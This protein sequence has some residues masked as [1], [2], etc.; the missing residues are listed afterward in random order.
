MSSGMTIFSVKPNIPKELSSLKDIS[1]NLWWCWNPEGVELFKRIDRKLWDKVDH[2]PVSLLSKVSQERLEELKNSES[3]IGHLNM[4]EKKLKS[5]MLSDAWY[6]NNIVKGDRKKVKYAYFSAEFGI[7]ESLPVYSGGL[8]ILAGDHLKSASDLGLPLAAVGLLYSGGYFNQKLN[9]E[10][11]QVEEYPQNDFNNMGISPATNDKGEEVEI[12][13]D[14]KGTE[15]FAKVWETKVGR[16][17]LYLLDTNIAKNPIEYRDIT[18]QLYG[19]GIVMRIKQEILLG[20]GGVRALKALGIESDVYHMNEGHSAFL[21]VENIRDYMAQNKISFYDAKEAVIAESVF[22]THTPVPA[23]N[24]RFEVEMIKE[25]FTDYIKDLG[26][27]MDDFLALGRENVNDEKETFCMTVLALKL[28]GGAN[29]VSK[30]H[31][32][33]SRGM[34]TGV[35]KGVPEKEIPIGHIT[36]GIHVPSWV[37]DDMTILFDRYLGRRWREEAY[38]QELW[39]RVDNIPNTEL[40]RTHERLRARLVSFIRERQVVQLQRNNASDQAIE[41]AKGVFSSDV[42][43]IGFARR[44]ATYKRG[45]LLFKDMERLKKIIHNSDR[46]VQFVFAGKAHPADNGGKALIKAVVEASRDPE[47]KNHIIFLEDYR[48]DVARYLVQGVDI[49]LNNPIRPLEASGTSGMKVVSNGGLN[50]SIKDGWW[51]EGTNGQN[52]FDIG[53]SELYNDEETRDHLE[54]QAIYETLENTIIPAF[55]DR[56]EDQMPMKWLK[57]M[58]NSMKTLTGVYHTNRQVKDYTEMYYVVAEKN[59][60]SVKKDSF[61]Q[62]LELN[63]KKYV[64]YRDWDNISFGEVSIERGESFVG[65]SLKITVPVTLGGEISSDLIFVQAYY[66]VIDNYDSMEDP[67]IS[68]LKF[69]KDENGVSI[70]EGKIPLSTSGRY[71]LKIRIVPSEKNLIEKFA[72][73]LIAWN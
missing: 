46:P 4:V 64:L 21:S 26:I 14:I 43:T 71:G 55:Y 19:G 6:Q 7:H 22:T 35:W 31:G 11:W 50:F 20:I 67:K 69:K 44:F 42:L 45:T 3:F 61:K 47:L 17:N 2:N 8:G 24:D 12:S 1:M 40:W 57:L 58:K 18:A 25:Y 38:D 60:R 59:G 49:W 9:G 72:P 68:D 23:G 70:F 5:Y 13:V 73:G 34:W 63:K 39:D 33:V 10:G 28:S 32:E 65:D 36:N 56:T 30:L 54:S 29:G 53:N 15:V 52:G 62:A 51:E 48:I 66:S 37:S 27:K 16:I 41:D